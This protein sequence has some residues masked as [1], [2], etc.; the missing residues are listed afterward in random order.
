LRVLKLYIVVNDTHLYQLKEQEPLMLDEKNLPVKLMAK[1]GFHFSRPFYITKH[2]ADTVLIGIGCEADNGT[3]W[4]GI[5]FS[6]L[7]F[8]IFL[9]TGF[10]AVMVLANLPLLYLVYKF[11]LKTKGFIIIEILKK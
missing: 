4:G 5:I 9:A 2:T 8:S 10:Y 6:L 11:F 3:L 7:F 1:N